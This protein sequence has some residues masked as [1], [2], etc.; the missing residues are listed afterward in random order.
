MKNIMENNV[1]ILIL[2]SFMSCTTNITDIKNLRQEEWRQLQVVQAQIMAADNV[3]RAIEITRDFVRFYDNNSSK[4]DILLLAETNNVNIKTF[5][6][7]LAREVM[8]RKNGDSLLD[9]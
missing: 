6:V 2:I 5:L 7:D 3:S 9:K 4:L 8:I 1:C